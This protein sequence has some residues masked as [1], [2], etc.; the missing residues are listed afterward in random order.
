MSVAFHAAEDGALPGTDEGILLLI[1]FLNI[2]HSFLEKR[3][4]LEYW[5]LFNL[6]QYYDSLKEVTFETEFVP[7]SREQV[8]V[9]DP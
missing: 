7:V 1:V 8:K 9:N 5:N 3:Q 4:L 2:N 6:D